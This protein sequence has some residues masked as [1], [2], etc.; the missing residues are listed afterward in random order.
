VTMTTRP[1]RS[2]TV[3]TSNGMSGR[4]PRLA[5]ARS[6]RVRL[7]PALGPTT[8]RRAAIPAGPSPPAQGQVRPLRAPG[9]PRLPGG[10]PGALAAGGNR[11]L[12]RGHLALE[13]SARVEDFQVHSPGLDHA[14]PGPGGPETGPA[15]AP[16]R[17]LCAPAEDRLRSRSVITLRACRSPCRIFATVMVDRD[18]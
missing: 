15:H 4:A 7:R 14:G 11:D 17:S 16:E 5:A 1:E 8:Q 13:R 9:H 12:G 3:A 18:C 6:L 10:R 2:I